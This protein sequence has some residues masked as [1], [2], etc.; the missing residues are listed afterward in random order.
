LINQSQTHA[1]VVASHSIFRVDGDQAN[2]PFFDIEDVYHVQ[3]DL[4]LAAAVALDVMKLLRE[5]NEGRDVV[6][7]IDGV[8]GHLIVLETQAAVLLEEMKATERY[9]KAE[10]ARL[11]KSG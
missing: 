10:A 7:F 1:N 4:W 9:Q 5:V 11:G 8:D 6:E 3:I 2:L